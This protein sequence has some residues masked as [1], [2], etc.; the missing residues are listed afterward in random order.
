[1][2]E[3]VRIA[4]LGC[5]VVGGAVARRLTQATD[6]FEAR[7]GRRL[8]IVGVAVRD[9]S[10]DRSDTGLDASLFTTDAEELVT[11]ADLVIE[12]MGGIDP[13]KSLLQKAI[14]SGASV[15]TANKALLGQHGAELYELAEEHG[16]DLYY[17]AAVAGAIPLIRPLRE[18]LAGDSVQ[19]VMGIVNGTTNFILDKMDRTG[20]DLAD[21][22]A[23]AQ[24]LGYAEADPTADVEGHDAQA[25]AAILA[26]LAFHTR[27]RTSDVAVEGIM[28]VT[29]DDIRA[30][31]RIGCVIKLLAIAELVDKD[32]GQAVSVRVHPTLLTRSHPLGSVRDAFNAVFVETELAGELMFYGRGAG[33]D[34]TA[35]AVLGDVVQA[36]RHKVHGGR[37][38]GESAYANLPIEGVGAAK[39]AYFI[40][41]DVQD[42][43]GVLAAI[44]KTIGEQGVSIESMRQSVRRS[45]DG[46][47]TLHIITHRS[48]E[49]DLAAVVE[50]LKAADEVDKIF[51]V[52][53]VEGE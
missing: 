30:A 17:E 51:S 15:V 14:E 45:Q 25:K 47:A 38:P 22:L 34:P 48:S 24:E 50:Q 33:G 31:R 32:G 19:R 8:E 53:R 43:P 52:L 21:V 18:S 20:A 40:R 26:S 11:R 6:E 4:L 10:K 13:T 39:T 12:L 36:A 41:M 37:G 35:S 2:S 16:A 23:E 1:M 3:S 9:T 46:L 5:G 49:A 42:K 7:V 28:S 27:V 44:A 29:A